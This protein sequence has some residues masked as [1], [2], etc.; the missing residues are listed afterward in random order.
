MT[1]MQQ[2]STVLMIAFMLLSNFYYF[3]DF[4]ESVIVSVVME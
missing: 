4:Y 1:V 3:Y 2:F